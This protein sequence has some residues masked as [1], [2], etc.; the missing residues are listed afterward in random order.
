MKNIIYKII[1][2]H[3]VFIISVL[4]FGQSTYAE[5]R[6]RNTRYQEEDV[7]R[8]RV[9]SV[10]SNEVRRLE[11]QDP[12]LDLRIPILFGV[13]WGNLDD[14]WGDARSGGRSHEGIDII[15]PRGEF[16][17][18]PTDAIVTTINTG[19]NGGKHVFT[20]NPGGERYYFAHLDGF[21]EDLDEGDVLK[22]GDLIGYVGNTGNA[23]GGVTHLHF[24]IYDESHG[25]LNPY[26]RLTREFPL[27]EKMEAFTKILSSSSNS[28]A[29]EQKTVSQ[30]K[31]TFIEAQA[32]GVRLPDS[33][34]QILTEKRTDALGINRILQSGMSGEDVKWLQA[35]LGI[36]ADGEFGPRTKA[37]V[38]AFQTKSG[39]PA[40]GIFGLTSR[41]ALANSSLAT[42]TLPSGC[43]AGAAFSTTTGARCTPTIVN[44]VVN[45]TALP[46]GCTTGAA[47]STT[48]GARCR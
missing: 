17:V 46:P 48:T 36:S 41:L 14:T 22:A 39:L 5:T 4:V 34:I 12:V 21:A 11:G 40:N 15:V 9:R 7:G 29:L 47:F 18:S 27:Q 20:T 1:V 33:T 13:A 23:S 24:G 44:T 3:L 26:L 30:Y 43:A 16:V 28:S 31:N 6:T 10:L 32:N 42:T 19:G 45:T 2:A 8:S 25:S 35:A 38:V 37:A